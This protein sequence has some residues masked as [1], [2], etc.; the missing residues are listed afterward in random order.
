MV[1]VSQVF[2][3]ISFPFVLWAPELSVDV[4]F[5]QKFWFLSICA[6]TLEGVL[7]NYPQW[8]SFLVG[9]GWKDM[10]KT[11]Y[12]IQWMFRN[13]NS[14]DTTRVSDMTRT[15]CNSIFVVC[16]SFLYLNSYYVILLSPP[17]PTPTHT[18]HN[19]AIWLF[20]VTDTNLSMS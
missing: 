8:H 3:L 7:L 2:M 16:N 14:R 5:I 4:I 13:G 12:H 9:E 11:L 20:I 18:H 6:T 10:R 15:R 1:G 19:A 17:T